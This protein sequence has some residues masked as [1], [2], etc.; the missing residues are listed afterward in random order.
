[1][2]DKSHM[3]EEDQTI[4][5]YYKKQADDLKT[6]LTR[7]LKEMSNL[8]GIDRS[9]EEQA[10]LSCHFGVTDAAH[11]AR[12]TR[13]RESW[14]AYKNGRATLEDLRAQN[15]M[16]M[17]AAIKKLR[18]ET[19]MG[20]MDCQKAYIEA[21]GSFYRAK[22]LLKKVGQVYLLKDDKRALL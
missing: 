16:F 11:C 12:C 14:L 8:L 21:D 19:G 9:L 13:E 20:I 22:E 17:I 10:G 6:T 5:R 7:V 15:E 1:M 2:D 18:E 3:I 4:I